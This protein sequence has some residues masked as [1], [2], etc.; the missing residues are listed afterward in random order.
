MKSRGKTDRENHGKILKKSGPKINRNVG[1][2]MKIEL[3]LSN[4][5]LTILPVYR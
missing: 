1:G 4:E 2:A 5:R 3:L